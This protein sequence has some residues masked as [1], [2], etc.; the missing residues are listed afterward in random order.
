MPITILTESELR[1]CVRLDEEV[2]AA[3]EEAFTAL[4]EGRAATPP[5]VHVNVPEH[6]GEV[7]IKTAYIQGLDSFAIKVASGFLDN[8]KLGL[9]YGSGLMLLWSATIGFPQAVLL[10]NGY[11]TDVRTA[12]AGAIAAKYLARQGIRTVGVVGAGMQG[13]YQA[14]ALRLVRDF[15]RVMVYDSAPERLEAYVREMP[16]ELGVEVV[17]ADGP[18]AILRESDVVITATPSTEP[19]VRAEW[20]HPGLHI[21]AMGADNVHKQELDADVLG[22]ADLRVCDLKSQVFRLGEHHHALDAGV[23]TEADDVAEL[24]EITSGRRPGRTTDAQITVCDL[25]GT[26]VQDTAI[27][28]LAY[29]KATAQGFGTPIEN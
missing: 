7:D 3:V 15:E 10:D 25:T 1:Q 12:A 13:R 26:G 14:A 22:R 4:A 8:Y 11:L 9:P 29:R 6:R 18:E 21:T 28:L 24:G 5:I 27:A 16:A 2:I 17:A 19:F 20:L 23:I